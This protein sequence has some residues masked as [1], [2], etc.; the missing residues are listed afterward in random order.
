MKSQPPASPIPAPQTEEEEAE[1]LRLALEDSEL[2]ELCQWVGL[3]PAL[4]ESAQ[5]AAARATP[6]AAPAQPAPTAM[7]RAPPARGGPPAHLY[8]APEYVILYSRM[9]YSGAS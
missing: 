4:H 8:E 3:T 7:S 5:Q 1:Q 2:H 6:A 9:M